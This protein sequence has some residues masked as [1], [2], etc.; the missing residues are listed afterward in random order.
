MH[1]LR[2]G[3]MLFASLGLSLRIPDIAVLQR[4]AVV[5][6]GSHPTYFILGF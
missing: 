2:D 6:G 4:T 1:M 5:V 3:L